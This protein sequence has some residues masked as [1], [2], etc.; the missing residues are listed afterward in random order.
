MEEKVKGDHSKS[1]KKRDWKL[2][3]KK[4]KENFLFVKGTASLNR[5]F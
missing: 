4:H 2:P 1:F 3:K 5:A